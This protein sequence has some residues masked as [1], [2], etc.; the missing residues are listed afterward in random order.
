M[1]A[2]LPS[3]D[4]APTPAGL[5]SPSFLFDAVRA[6]Q[7]PVSVSVRRAVDLFGPWL[8]SRYIRYP[9]YLPSVRDVVELQ[10]GLAEQLVNVQRDFA[11]DLLDAAGPALA[12]ETDTRTRQFGPVPER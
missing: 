1:P 4:R 7:A 11:T 3:T 6:W 2:S 10:L 12:C 5:P 9:S 8:P